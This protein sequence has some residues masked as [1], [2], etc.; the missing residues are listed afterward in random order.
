MPTAYPLHRQ[1]QQPSSAGRPT[2]WIELEKPSNQAFH[3]P[4]RSL[5][6]SRSGHQHHQ[7]GHA[8]FQ[9]LQQPTA[10]ASCPSAS[11]NWSPQ[12]PPVFASRAS[13][14]ANWSLPRQPAFELPLPP[15]VAP[16]MTCAPTSHAMVHGSGQRTIFAQA[17]QVRSQGDKVQMKYVGQ[18][19]RFEEEDEEQ[20]LW[21]LIDA[22]ERHDIEQEEESWSG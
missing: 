6:R 17:T 3:H 2:V 8:T 20:L 12:P 5:Q 1:E 4:S 19:G 10:F 16:Q 14:S 11:A 13:A 21:R 9:S 18:A 7:N 22:S 15:T